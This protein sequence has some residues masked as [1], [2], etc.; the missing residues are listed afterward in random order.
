M[1]K[2]IKEDKKSGTVTLE[3]ELP[4]RRTAD[5]PVVSFL[6]RD[7]K[8]LLKLEGI[9]VTGC[10]KKDSITNHR[11]SDSHKGQW[12]FDVKSASK[13]PA[14][15]KESLTKNVEPAIIDAKKPT[16]SQRKGK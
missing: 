14:K 13:A 3:V 2:S 16:S 6:T 11:E 12:I 10:R 7:A 9:V 4:H 1:N 15:K 8:M 5:D